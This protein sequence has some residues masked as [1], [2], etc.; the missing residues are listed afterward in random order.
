MLYLMGA[1]KL[2][3]I[4]S[5]EYSNSI[6]GLTT[7]LFKLLIREAKMKWSKLN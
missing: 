2:L 6:I 5:E 4:S 1:L 7:V 3:I